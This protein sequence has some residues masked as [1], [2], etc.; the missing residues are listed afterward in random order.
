MIFARGSFDIVYKFFDFC[1][2][3]RGIR[4]GDLIDEIGGVNGVIVNFQNLIEVSLQITLQSGPFGQTCRDLQRVQFPRSLGLQEIIKED[5]V[6]QQIGGLTGHLV[7]VLG[8]PGETPALLGKPAFQ[9]FIK[10]GGFMASI[11]NYAPVIGG[12][13]PHLFL[14]PIDQPFIYRLFRFRLFADVNIV[15]FS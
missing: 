8:L 14:N 3:L 1:H 9:F 11:V 5:F 13:R 6:Y 15:K 7:E 12:Q 2:H 10:D 4:K